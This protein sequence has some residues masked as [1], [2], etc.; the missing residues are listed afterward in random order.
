MQMGGQTVQKHVSI[1][2]SVL[3]ATKDAEAVVIATEWPEFK[4]I[5]WAKV[6]N[7]MKKPAFL[8]DGRLL[9]NGD[10]LR[11]IGFKVSLGCG[12]SGLWMDDVSDA[13]R[14]ALLVVANASK[15]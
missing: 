14:L 8:F 7:Q 2:H 5:D 6:Y 15:W 13:H 10:E 11:K 1:T 12:S 3:E 9:V 4:Q